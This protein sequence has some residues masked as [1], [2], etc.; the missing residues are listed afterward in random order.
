LL[1][2]ILS[3]LFFVLVSDKLWISIKEKLIQRLYDKE[4]AIRTQA[5]YALAR[6]QVL[7]FVFVFPFLS[8]KQ[9]SK[10]TPTLTQK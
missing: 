4:P 2:F 6:L 3:F 5:V 7:F 10:Q 8:S 9:A 1:L